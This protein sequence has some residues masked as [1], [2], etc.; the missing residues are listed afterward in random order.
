MPSSV[1]YAAAD[2]QYRSE[3]WTS[4]FVN[5][6]RNPPNTAHAAMRSAASSACAFRRCPRTAKKC[7]A[8][9]SPSAM[10]P[11]SAATRSSSL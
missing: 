3:I 9:Y 4:P 2:A 8:R 11:P 10:S 7:P 5:I 1:Q 6:A